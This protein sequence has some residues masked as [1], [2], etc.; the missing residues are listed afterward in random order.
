M[1]ISIQRNNYYSFRSL[2]SLRKSF[3]G[4]I[5]QKHKFFLFVRWNSG[6]MKK[7][8]F[9][10]IFGKHAHLSSSWAVNVSESQLSSFLVHRKKFTKKLKYFFPQH[11]N[12]LN[13]PNIL[14]YAS[15][16]INSFI[17]P[18]KFYYIVQSIILL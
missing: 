18:N 16:R 9:I 12:E 8:I 10:L 1:V 13:I 14:K 17:Y 2:K 5:Y 15:K 3:L 7:D 4:S 6:K 11:P